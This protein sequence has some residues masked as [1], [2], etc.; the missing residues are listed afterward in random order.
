MQNAKQRYIKTLAALQDYTKG[1]KASQMNQDNRMRYDETE[2]EDTDD[3]E[4]PTD[5]CKKYKTLT[6]I[7]M[8]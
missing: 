3:V 1:N 5:P 2:S 6:Q 8:I 4:F 7:Q